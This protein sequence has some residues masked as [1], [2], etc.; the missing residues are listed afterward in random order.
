M[1]EIALASRQLMTDQLINLAFELF[2]NQLARLGRRELGLVLLG[3][4]DVM[5][6]LQN[7]RPLH[8]VHRITVQTLANFFIESPVIR[9]VFIGRCQHFKADVPPRDVFVPL[10][11]LL[12][13]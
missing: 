9:Q 4:H 8:P 6:L 1:R 13:T 7:L 2:L 3:G 11:P 12:G 10:R 5:G